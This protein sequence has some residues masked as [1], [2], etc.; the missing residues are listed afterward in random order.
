MM[1]LGLCLK[2]F[3]K[4]VFFLVTDN[5]L[6]FCVDFFKTEVKPW[7]YHIPISGITPKFDKSQFND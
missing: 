4:S 6:Y 5:I 2:F 7:R 3:L 1:T